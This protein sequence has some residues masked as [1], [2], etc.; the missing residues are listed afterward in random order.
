MRQILKQKLGKTVNTKIQVVTNQD[1]WEMTENL[2]VAIQGTTE[3]CVPTRTLSPDNWNCYEKYQ[4]QSGKEI[5][6]EGKGREYE[7]MEVCFSLL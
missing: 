3:A 6:P 2:T 4:T 7:I 5:T 1:L